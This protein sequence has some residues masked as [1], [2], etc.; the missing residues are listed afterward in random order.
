M[1]LKDL[2]LEIEEKRLP[3]LWTHTVSLVTPI[4]QFKFVRKAIFEASTA[5]ASTRTKS[6]LGRF[7]DLSVL[8]GVSNSNLDG[9][10]GYDSSEGSPEV[11]A[12]DESFDWFNFLSFAYD[13]L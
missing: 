8:G 7:P 13:E 4:K 12:D 10:F 11:A 1:T 9:S 2:L 6:D 5:S 3:T